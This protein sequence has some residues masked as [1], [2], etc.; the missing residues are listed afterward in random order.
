[1]LIS[2]ISPASIAYVVIPVNHC[3]VINIVNNRISAFIIPAVHFYRLLH[4]TK[5]L[6]ISSMLT[7]II[8]IQIT[9]SIISQPLYSLLQY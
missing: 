3:I 7:M 1:M 2:F 5:I 6:Y 4:S 9:V 8:L